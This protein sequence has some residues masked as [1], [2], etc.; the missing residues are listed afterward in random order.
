MHSLDCLAQTHI[1]EPHQDS[2]VDQV[3]IHCRSDEQYKEIFE[4]S[5]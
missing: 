3:C 1:A 5:I 2:T 4:Q